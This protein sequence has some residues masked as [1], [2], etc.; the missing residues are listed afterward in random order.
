M[1][2]VLRGLTQLLQAGQVHAL[3]LHTDASCTCEAA[4]TALT[5]PASKCPIA[6][7]PVPRQTAMLSRYG[8][9]ERVGAPR[10]AG[11]APARRA[12]AGQRRV[13]RHARPH[14][15]GHHA[16]DRSLELR[17]GCE[18]PTVRCMPRAARCQR[19]H[20][21]ARLAGRAGGGRPAG[22]RA[23]NQGG[24]AAGEAA[25]RVRICTRGRQDRRKHGG[26]ARRRAPQQR[27][28]VCG[29][30]RAA[31]AR[32]RARGAQQ[33]GQ[34]GHAGR[35]RQHAQLGRA[36]RHTPVRPGSHACKRT[37]AAICG[38]WA[39]QCGR[40]AVAC[41]LRALAGEP[42]RVQSYT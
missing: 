21:A 36:A 38:A 31:H 33:H 39:S 9:A 41:Q 8:H 5:G 12:L 17:R 34:R 24:P 3:S 14:Q 26:R 20:A 19:A 11:A 27:A 28:P 15:L 7:H 40:H 23:P 35:R 18:A 2:P 25:L 13:G 30:R 32:V 1:L 4:G 6:L 10:A 16:R 42:R 29:P 37:P 22:G